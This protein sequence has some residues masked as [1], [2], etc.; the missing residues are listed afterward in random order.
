MML[1][2]IL[3]QWMEMQSGVKGTN[4]FEYCDNNA[5]NRD[6][7]GGE[8]SLPLKHASWII[9]T[10]IFTIMSLVSVN[11]LM[12]KARSSKGI[13]NKIKKIYKNNVW[14]IKK[15]AGKI[16]RRIIKNRSKAL[17]IERLLI[18][19]LG[20]VLNSIVIFSSIGHFLQIF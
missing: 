13:I 19:A 1:G 20:T 15:C 12:R 2:G 6:D 16:V 4:L 7:L 11:R 8:W 9:D 5:V 18:R 14:R 3:Y 17:L 10:I